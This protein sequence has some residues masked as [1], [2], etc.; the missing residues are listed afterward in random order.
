MTCVASKALSGIIVGD[1]LPL[2][3]THCAEQRLRFLDILIKMFVLGLLTKTVSS[4]A[5]AHFECC[6]NPWEV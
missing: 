5:G 3:V 2:E 4:H 6:V 1:S